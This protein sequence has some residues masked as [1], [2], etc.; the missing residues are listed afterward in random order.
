MYVC[1]CSCVYV[2]SL[3]LYIS[4]IKKYIVGLVIKLSSDAESAEVSSH[5]GIHTAILVT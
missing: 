5:S 2:L 3:L 1:V 4:G